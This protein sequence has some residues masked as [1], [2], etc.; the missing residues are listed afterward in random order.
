[1]NNILT[2]CSSFSG[3][4]PELTTVLK[5][6][7][8]WASELMEEKVWVGGLIAS[9]TQCTVTE[10]GLCSFGAAVGLEGEK[11]RHCAEFSIVWPPLPAVLW[12]QGTP[13]M[14]L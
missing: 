6:A 14:I 3:A 9:A 11:G 12:G 7:K 4:F 2:P 10:S 5:L 13:S 1:M 8:N